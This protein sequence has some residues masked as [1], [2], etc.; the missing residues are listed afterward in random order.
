MSQAKVLSRD[1]FSI[2][3][4]IRNF[5]F[6]DGF[7]SYQS[8]RRFVLGKKYASE[9]TMSKF[10]NDLK[11]L[12]A[13]G[14]GVVFTKWGGRWRSSWTVGAGTPITS[15]IFRGFGRCSSIIGSAFLEQIKGQE[16]F[17]F[18]DFKSW[19]PG[20]T[21]GRSFQEGHVYLYRFTCWR[22]VTSRARQ[23]CWQFLLS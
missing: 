14:F 16:S 4:R 7:E 6:D 9:S 8:L 23:I 21:I 10:T 15:T 11:V 22:Q 12:S 5:L 3:F 1:V 2:R 19:S 20:S 18:H 13:Y 17:L